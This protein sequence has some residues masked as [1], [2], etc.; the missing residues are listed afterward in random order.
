MR[1][2]FSPKSV[3]SEERNM[4]T[5]TLN[6]YSAEDHNKV[7]KTYTTESYDLM[8]GTVE[9]LIQIIDVDKMTDNIAV[10]RI[11]V[12]SFGK[13]KPFIKDVFTGVTDEELKRIKVKE[14]IPAFIEI[15][16]GIVDGLDLVKSGN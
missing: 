13:L 1:A 8:F 7:E 11:V 9:D 14:L 3:L 6:V 5:I 2:A 4:A 15:C 12:Q 10:T 16:K